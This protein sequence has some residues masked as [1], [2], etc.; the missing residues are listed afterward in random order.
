M[1]TGPPGVGKS[2]FTIWIAGPLL[3]CAFDINIEQMDVLF[4]GGGEL[5]S[6]Q[7]KRWNYGPLRLMFSGQLGV[8]VYRLCLSSPRLTD[9]RLAQHLGQLG[10]SK[11]MEF[12]NLLVAP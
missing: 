11:G 1:I 6:I 12:A 4:F 8:P 2:E 3:L 7:M 10:K 9:D 5:K